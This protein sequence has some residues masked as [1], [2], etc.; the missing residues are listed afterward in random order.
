MIARV[1]LDPPLGLALGGISRLHRSQ[2]SNMIR[3]QLIPIRTEPESRLVTEHGT[4]TI[5]VSITRPNPIPGIVEEQMNIPG[6]SS[7]SEIFLETTQGIMLETSQENDK[8]ES[9]GL[10]QKEPH[11]SEQIT[12]EKG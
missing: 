7:N 11:S 12:Q 3:D 6:T 4:L 1:D 5:Q 10:I 2:D 8:Q 9:G